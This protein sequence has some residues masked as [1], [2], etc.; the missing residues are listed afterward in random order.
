[1]NYAHDTQKCPATDGRARR[2]APRTARF[3]GF[4]EHR[5]SLRHNSYSILAVQRSSRER[6]CTSQGSWDEA[7][8]YCQCLC[9]KKAAFELYTQSL[10][11]FIL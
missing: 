10:L 9:T 5:K 7:P 6:A 8:S 4:V 11:L 3:D 2:T 1:M